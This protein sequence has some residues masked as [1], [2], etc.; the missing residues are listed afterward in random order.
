MA[1]LELLRLEL[2][3]AQGMKMFADVSD[4][5]GKPKKKKKDKERKA[6]IKT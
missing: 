6:V 3:E 4:L 2:E 5:T 1:A